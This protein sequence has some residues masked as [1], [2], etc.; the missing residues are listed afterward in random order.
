MGR[1]W[2]SICGEVHRRE[3]NHIAGMNR[4]GAKDAKTS[5][6]IAIIESA[7][8]GRPAREMTTNS[9]NTGFLQEAE[10][11]ARL[12]YLLRPPPPRDRAAPPDDPPRLYCWL[13]WLPRWRAL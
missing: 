1:P 5:Q 7:L 13:R 10:L 8:C 4:K 9:P 2:S 3:I 11:R 6:S 12:R